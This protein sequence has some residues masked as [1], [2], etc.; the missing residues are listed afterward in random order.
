[1]LYVIQPSKVEGEACVPP[2]K[3]QSIRALYFAALA[4]GTSTLKNLLPSPDIEQAKLSISLLGADVE[5]GEGMWTIR[6]CAGT[7]HTPRQVMDAG[8]SGLVFRLGIALSALAPETTLVTGDASICHRRPSAPLLAAL[9]ELGAKSWVSCPGQTAPVVVCGQLKGGEVSMVSGDSQPASALMVAAPFTEKG[10]LLDLSQV[11]ERPWLELT[12]SWLSSRGIH[13][14]WQEEK[15]WIPGRQKL[16]PFSYEVCGDWSSAAFLVAAGMVT[17]GRVRVRGLRHGDGQGDQKLFAALKGVKWEEKEDGIEL[18]GGEFEGGVL[19]CEPFIDA[20]PILAVLGCY[21]RSPLQ[22]TGAAVARL[23][24]SDR[25]ASITA[26][27][28]KMGAH[29]E[30]HPDGLTVCPSPLRGAVLQAHQDHRM[31][32]ALSVAA[33][34]ARG[35]SRVEGVECVAKTFPHFELVLT[36]LG[37]HMRRIP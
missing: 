35:E 19:N 36:D 14:E 5:R 15:V 22:L 34:G 27:L 8:N 6:G 25:I 11:G 28:R 13:W 30:E 3:S 7:P 33:L 2:S 4:H 9:N 24:E 31:A 17:G 10:V 16:E 23:K 26:E 21:A 18:Q 12:L 32:M 20:L 29:I 1:M 37:A